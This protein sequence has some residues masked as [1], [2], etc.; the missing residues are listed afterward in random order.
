MLN[1]KK[2]INQCRTMCNGYVFYTID[3]VRN[4]FN[5]EL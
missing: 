5:T 4:K 3:Y 2:K 1:Q